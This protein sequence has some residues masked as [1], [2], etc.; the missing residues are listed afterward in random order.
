MHSEV[1][2]SLQRAGE[3]AR[4]WI[5]GVSLI[6]QHVHELQD[7]RVVRGAVSGV[8]LGSEGNYSP[9]SG[10]NN[11][12]EPRDLLFKSAQQH[13]NYSPYLVAGCQEQY[14]F[15]FSVPLEQVCLKQ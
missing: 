13:V 1:I 3:D 8:Q 2:K 12:L 15:P 6:D 5:V 4:V 9:C 11:Q 10:D 14:S 7:T